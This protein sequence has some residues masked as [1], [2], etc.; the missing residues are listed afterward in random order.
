MNKLT[1]KPMSKKTN[2]NEQQR[3]QKGIA[4]FSKDTASKVKRGRIQKAKEPQSMR[5]IE[6]VDQR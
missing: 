3:K 2:K 1:S 6:E 4:K 5:T